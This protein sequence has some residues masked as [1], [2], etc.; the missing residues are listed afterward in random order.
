MDAAYT[1]DRS[2]FR[3]LFWSGP[4][5]FHP[6]ERT[7]VGPAYSPLPLVASNG[8]AA[9]SSRSLTALSATSR[10]FPPL[11]TALRRL[12]QPSARPTGINSPDRGAQV[13]DT[14]SGRTSSRL[15]RSRR[16]GGNE[17]SGPRSM[18]FRAAYGWG[19][20]G[21]A[22]PRPAHTAATPGRSL[23]FGPAGE[24][25]T[26]RRGCLRR[27]SPRT[28]SSPGSPPTGRSTR[29]ACLRE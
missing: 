3:G 12:H 10:P 23:N 19:R 8:G 5:D 17:A 13:R 2:T 4:T 28:R 11:G 18:S 6:R 25:V 20:C 7:P 26:P 22:L 27:A 9:S 16:T 24:R 14:R 29:P 15:D 21:P 1:Q